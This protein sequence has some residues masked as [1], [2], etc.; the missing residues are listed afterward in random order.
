[1]FFICLI[2][3]IENLVKAHGTM[4]WPLYI[5]KLDILM[6]KSLVFWDVLEHVINTPFF[7]QYSDWCLGGQSLGLSA[8]T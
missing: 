4:Q 5:L 1:M 6:F 3:I 2:C 7:L 8:V